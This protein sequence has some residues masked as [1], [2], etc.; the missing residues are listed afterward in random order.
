MMSNHGTA[1]WMTRMKQDQVKGLH[2]IKESLVIMI[3]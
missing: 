2:S 3:T 1:L